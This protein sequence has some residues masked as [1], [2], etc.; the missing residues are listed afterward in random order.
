MTW[1]SHPYLQPSCVNQSE[2]YAV[3]FSVSVEAVAGGAG[4]VLDDGQ[5]LAN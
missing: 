5:R 2:R 3:P 1:D 4:D